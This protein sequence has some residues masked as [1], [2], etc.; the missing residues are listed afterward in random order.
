MQQ[1]R[2][3]CGICKHNSNKEVSLGM[4]IIEA[5]IKMLLSVER[6]VLV[7]LWFIHT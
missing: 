7:L 1:K 3:S 6:L 2:A 4:E 5:W